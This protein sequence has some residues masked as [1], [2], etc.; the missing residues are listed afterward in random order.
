MP[1]IALNAA[2]AKVGLYSMIMIVIV[3]GGAVIRVVVVALPLASTVGSAIHCQPLALSLAVAAAPVRLPASAAAPGSGQIQRAPVPAKLHVLK[4]SG[5]VQGPHG[6]LYADRIHR[7][8][9]TDRQIVEDRTLG[10]PLQPFHPHVP[11]DEA[12]LGGRLNGESGQQD[13][14]Q[15]QE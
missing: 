8:P 2:P 3:L 15:D 14:G 4:Q 7:V 5:P 11:H 12:R 1:F 13:G 6:F 9:D 10:D